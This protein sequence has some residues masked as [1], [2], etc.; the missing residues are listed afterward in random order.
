MAT[1][2]F[3]NKNKVRPIKNGAAKRARVKVQ[4]KRLVDM[5]FSAEEV[6]KMSSEKVHDYLRTPKL[7]EKFLKRRAEEAAAPQA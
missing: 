1:S 6:A 3:R 4:Q 2:T 5:G 7:T